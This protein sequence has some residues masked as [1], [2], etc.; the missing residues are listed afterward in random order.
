MTEVERRREAIIGRRGQGWTW[1]RIGEEHGIS[2]TQAGKLYRLGL[3]DRE[4]RKVAAALAAATLETPVRELGLEAAVMF[5][6]THLR[7]TD[8]A[9]V[10]AY[11]PATLIS[12]LLTYPD[13]GRRTLVPLDRL[14]KKFER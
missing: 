10:L 14:R 4:K 9:S 2:R 1:D 6:L 12:L 7:C 13:I 11:R 3:N 8:L 5:A